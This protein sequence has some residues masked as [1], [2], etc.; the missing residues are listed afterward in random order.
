[1]ATQAFRTL[2][3]VLREPCG[4]VC[5]CGKDSTMRAYEFQRKA[6]RSSLSAERPGCRARSAKQ[7]PLGNHPCICV[8]CVSFTSVGDR[9]M[10]RAFSV[11]KATFLSNERSSGSNDL[12]GVSD[13]TCSGTTTLPPCHTHRL[14]R[15][16]CV[17]STHF[18]LIHVYQCV[19]SIRITDHLARRHRY[20]QPQLLSL[21]ASPPQKL[22]RKLE[23]PM[24]A[25]PQAFG[26]SQPATPCITYLHVLSLQLSCKPTSS[27]DIHDGVTSAVTT[28]AT[29]T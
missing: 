26:C 21:S 17:Y 1:M 24:T 11:T 20:A 29:G 19:P 23:V 6:L 16:V 5:G 28:I 18:T 3:P 14:T 10:F 8:C 25:R 2:P 13:A 4:T 15:S 9:H 27:L 22:E 7:P 12:K